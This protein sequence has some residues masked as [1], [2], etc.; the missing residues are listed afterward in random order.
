[1]RKL[2]TA[3]VMLIAL[4]ALMACDRLQPSAPDQLNPEPDYDEAYT[5]GEIWQEYQTHPYANDQYLNRW[6]VV[7]LQGVKPDRGIDYVAG[8][9]VIIRTPGK[10]SEMNFHYRFI[11][12]TEDLDRGDQP[13]A[14]CSVKGLNLTQNKLDFI[15]CRHADTEALGVTAVEDRTQE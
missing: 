13:Y 1:M 6:L 3:L 12:D 10:I 9:N 7:K 14:L 11:E 15:H 4:T 5:A 8:K 2:T